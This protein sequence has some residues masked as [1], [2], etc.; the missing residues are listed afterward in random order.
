MNPARSLL[1]DTQN[2]DGGWGA[3]AGR[4]STTEIT[5]LVTLA[6]R[7]ES[8]SIAAAAQVRGLAWLRS[9]QRPDGSWPPAEG[10]P[11]S[12]WMTSLA[13]LALAGS[14]TDRSRALAGGRWLLS[15][16]GRGYSWLTKLIFRLFPDR[17]VI[18]LDPDLTGWPWYEDTFS[19]VEPTAYALLALKTLR[20]GLPAD[21]TVARIQEGESMLLDRSCDGGGWNYGNSRVFDEDLWPYPDTTAIALIA[22]RDLG[23][24]SEI[25]SGLVA[26]ERMLEE[27]DSLLASALGL[28]CFQAYGRR[29]DDLRKRIEARLEGDPGWADLRGI[30]LAALALSENPSFGISHG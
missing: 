11:V 7:G 9:R 24:R 6:L 2:P 16:E 15:Q 14:G 29:T 17:D 22:L 26:L 13:V 4:T 20:A 25:S 3:S 23:N 10:I 18:E 28:L 8:D 12:T 1:V 27:N 5:S 30:A 21:S 19:W